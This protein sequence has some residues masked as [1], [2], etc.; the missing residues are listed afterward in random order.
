MQNKWPKKL[1]KLTPKQ[2][3]IRDDFMKYWHEILPKKF[4]FIEHFSHNYPVRN[5]KIG[6]KVL[7]I[8]AGLG[9]QI[10]YEDLDQVAYYAMELRRE[11]A[12]VIKKRFPKVNVLV[13]DCQKKIPYPDNYFDRVQAIHVLEHLPN[14]PKALA[15]VRR[16][17]KREGEFCVVIPC[18]GGLIH[19]IGRIFSGKRVFEA[20]YGVSY[21]WCIKS[22]H[23]N[24]AKEVLDELAQRF[25][26]IKQEFYPLKAP[27]L[28]LNLFLGM[29]L[30]PIKK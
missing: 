29:V 3:R 24:T 2:K 5:C 14:L 19:A 30:K 8:G 16:V 28:D 10:S 23:V 11:M 15:E 4:G 26:T 9:D 27:F 6:G 17:L 25:K 22:E 1:P 20:R 13:G 12:K 21:D 18:E 7:E